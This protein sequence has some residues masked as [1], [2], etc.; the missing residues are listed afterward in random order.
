MS[1]QFIVDRHT[2]PGTPA[3]DPVATAK[4]PIYDTM[5]DVT[6]DLANLTVGQIIGITDTGDELSHPVDV[7][8]EGNLHA[9]SS[10]AVAVNCPRFPD[11]ARGNLFTGVTSSYTATEDCYV[12]FVL[13]ATGAMTVKVDNVEVGCSDSITSVAVTTFNGFLKKGQKITVNTS[14]AMVPSRFK[15]FGLIGA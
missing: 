10:N 13:V 5:T 4:V 2:T 8:E 9:V 3:L 1:K 7:V 14:N 12:Q 11:Y 6:A 15:V